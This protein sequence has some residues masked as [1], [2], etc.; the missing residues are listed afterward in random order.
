MTINKSQGQTFTTVGMY[1]PVPCFSHGQ[2]HVAMS[3]VGS[4]DRIHMLITHTQPKGDE[5]GLLYTDD[6]VYK[7]PAVLRQQES[8]A[9]STMHCQTSIQS[10]N[11]NNNIQSINKPH[12]GPPPRLQRA[13]LNLDAVVATVLVRAVVGAMSKPIAIV[14]LDVAR[15]RLA[16]RV[17]VATTAIHHRVQG[18]SDKSTGATTT[19]AGGSSGPNTFT[20]S[21]APH[22]CSNVTIPSSS[23]PP[24][25]P[26]P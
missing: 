25:P 13:A 6:I 18:R 2:L 10:I 12:V 20:L 9:M 22:A 23:T 3:H 24:P 7:E 21:H 26:P 14:A 16:T 19:N 15:V 4:P 11:N 1:L 8:L 5:P 17:T